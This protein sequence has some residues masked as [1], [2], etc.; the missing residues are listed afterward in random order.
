MDD[1]IDVAPSE[2]VRSCVKARVRLSNFVLKAK[3]CHATVEKYG[4]DMRLIDV[5]VVY[6][7]EEEYAQ[8]GQ[9]DDYIVG[10]ALAKAGVEPA[11][12]ITEPITELITEPIV[13]PTEPIEPTVEPIVEPIVEE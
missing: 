1:L 4:A 12:T 11:T 9:D 7:N 13:E 8:W 2:I 5:A 6:I 3:D 10:L